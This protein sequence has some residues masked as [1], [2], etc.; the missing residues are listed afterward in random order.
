MN[1]VEIKNFFDEIASGSG[2]SVKFKKSLTPIEKLNLNE[3]EVIEKADV[4]LNVKAVRNLS[5]PYGVATDEKGVLI[6]MTKIAETYYVYEK[7]VNDEDKST[8]ENTLVKDEV[9][10]KTYDNSTSAI[11]AIIKSIKKYCPERANEFIELP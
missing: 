5:G 8:K 7:I 10:C 6:S 4:W 3:Q 1:D 2:L 9:I 11:G